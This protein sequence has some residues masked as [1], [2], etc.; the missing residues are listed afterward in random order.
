[1]GDINSGTYRF[2]TDFTLEY[3]SGTKLWTKNDSDRRYH[4]LDDPNIQYTIFTIPIG[5]GVFKKI[6]YAVSKREGN[7]YFLNERR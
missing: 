4:R 2:G 1:M 6:V 3:D 7:W 5:N